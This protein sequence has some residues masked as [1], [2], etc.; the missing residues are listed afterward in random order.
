MTLTAFRFLLKHLSNRRLLVH[1]WHSG[2]EFT[3]A[4]AAERVRN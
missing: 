1:C 4:R 3:Y 2:F